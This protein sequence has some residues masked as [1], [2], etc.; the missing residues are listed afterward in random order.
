[1][2]RKN[3]RRVEH[4]GTLPHVTEV[5][6]P[7][8]MDIWMAR[9]PSHQGNSLQGGTRPVLVVSNNAANVYSPVVTVL[10]MTTK[11]KHLTQP[12]HVVLPVEGG[13]DSLVLAEQIT[14]IPKRWLIQQLGRC[15]SEQKRIEEAMR[16][17][18]GLGEL[19]NE[20]NHL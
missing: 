13:H 20:S 7:A 15:E 12:T 1:M 2:G 19:K 4:T 17:Q 6:T 10:P 11:M 18:I 8:R 16:M 14:T 5:N 9:L 3:N